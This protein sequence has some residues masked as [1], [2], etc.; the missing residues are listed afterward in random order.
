[1]TG[2]TREKSFAWTGALAGV[3]WIGQAALFRTDD[4][5]RPGRATAD[6]I[7]SDLV[8]N[9]VAIGCLVVMGIALVFFGTALSG[10][11]QSGGTAGAAYGSV[12]NGG[13]LLAGAGLAQMVVWHWGLVN[14]AADAAD[15]SALRVLSFVSFFAFAGMGIGLS[16]TMLA[17]GAAGLRTGVLPR[18]FSIVTV[19]MGVL[20]AL[21]N[22]GV[23]P[24][25]LVTYLLVPLWLVT[26][27]VI[28]ARRGRASA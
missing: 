21:G 8:L 14:G 23:P 7:R 20:G 27:S 11:L 6:V 16:A 24:G 26:T 22:A 13:V 5:G 10:H 17:T 12:A 3:A 1:M 25:G 2:S 19:V 15:D 4:A 28:I 9:H 18:W